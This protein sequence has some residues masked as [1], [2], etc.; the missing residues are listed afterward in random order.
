MI[1]DICVNTYTYLAD[2]WGPPAPNLVPL[3]LVEQAVF[4]I[5]LFATASSGAHR[6]ATAKGPR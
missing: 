3:Y 5:F 4:R 1:A 2:Y 6:L